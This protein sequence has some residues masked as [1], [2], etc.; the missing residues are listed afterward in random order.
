MRTD[1]SRAILGRKVNTPDKIRYD[2]NYFCAIMLC[3]DDKSGVR[4][5]FF[6]SRTNENAEIFGRQIRFC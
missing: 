5:A 1:H 4:M 3:R 6:R 2:R